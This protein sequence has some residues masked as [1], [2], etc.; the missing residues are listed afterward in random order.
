MI[1]NSKQISLEKKTTILQIAKNQHR[2][3]E[4]DLISI[5][6]LTEAFI[7][8]GQNNTAHYVQT[9]L[10]EIALLTQPLGNYFLP[11]FNKSILHDDFPKSFPTAINSFSDG[12]NRIDRCIAHIKNQ[13]RLQANLHLSKFPDHFSGNFL[14]DSLISIT[15]FSESWIKKNVGHDNKWL[16]ENNI[17]YS[18]NLTHIF[19]SQQKDYWKKNHEIIT[20]CSQL[21]L[22]QFMLLKMKDNLDFVEELELNFYHAMTFAHYV[23]YS[24]SIRLNHLDRTDINHLKDL[25]PQ[26]FLDTLEINSYEEF[27]VYLYSVTNRV[28]KSVN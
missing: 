16:I 18:T 7:L 2:E 13:N 14:A 25:T 19:I 15:G 9:E 12:I 27:L 22:E 24:L 3:D 26:V 4:N 1:F 21:W 11:W 6:N 20:F 23:L 10:K 8:N 17:K 5:D 28:W